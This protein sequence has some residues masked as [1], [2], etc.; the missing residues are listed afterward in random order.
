M[1]GLTVLGNCANSYRIQS[2][3]IVARRQFSKLQPWKL[4]TVK[5]SEKL[6]TTKSFYI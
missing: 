5:S 4:V 3:K 1:V 6:Q 2:I